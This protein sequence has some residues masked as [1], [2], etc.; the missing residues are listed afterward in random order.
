MPKNKKLGDEDIL[1]RVNAKVQAS[2]SWFDSKVSKENEKVEQY[3]D[4]VLPRKQK[5]GNSGYVS[6]D[7][8][9]SVESMKAQ[10]LETFGGGY[11]IVRFD[12]QGPEDVKL[13]RSCTLYTEK[14]IFQHND[15]W[16]IF[17][18][19]IDTGLKARNAVAQVYWQ[20]KTAYDEHSFSRM[21]LSQAQGLA[22]QEDVEIEAEQNPF[23]AIDIEPTYKGSWRRKIDKGGVKI[24]V[25]P[26]EEF[27]VEKRV[28]CR[29]DG[30]RGRRH[31]KTRQDLLDEGY[32]KAKVAKAGT[33][34]ADQIKF[35]QEA[36]ARYATTD[37]G[38]ALNGDAAQPELEPILLY[39]TYIEL[40]LEDRKAL[41]HVVHTD[42]VLFSCDEVD[43][44]PYVE[45]AP[46]RRAHAWYGNNYAAK[47][48]PTQ[49]ARTVLTRGVLDHT[50][51]TINPRW[52]VLN[53][54][55]QTPRE[56]LD[57]RQGGVVN[58]KMRDG[59]APLP[60]ANLNPHVF[61]VLEM[62]K[63][64]KEETTG[65]SALSQGLNKDAIS[66]Q[67]S[68]GLVGDLVALSQVRQ[69]VVARNF[70]KFVMDL[71]VKVYRCVVE[72]DRRERIEEVSG[73]YIEV[74]PKDWI[75]QRDVT[76]SLHL[77]YG[78]QEKRAMTMTTAYAGIAQDPVLSQ[79]FTLPKRRKMATD[80]LEERG[81]KNFDEYLELAENVQPPQP[82]PIELAKAQ[83]DKARADAALVTAQAGA[84]KVEQDGQLGL[85]KQQ[86]AEMQAQL[87]AILD[88]READRQD[89]DV[90]N[91]V[92]VSQR[93][94]ELAEAA[95][96]ESANNIISPN[97]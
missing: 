55:L 5:E 7:V 18:D 67:N 88:A 91:R 2:V 33:A 52:Q 66:T 89:L 92:D 56:L 54:A 40:V 78:E 90:A 86:L 22:S 16:F 29:T 42:S 41:Y 36:Q 71:W 10:L 63:Q 4:Q 11:K 64:N 12:P 77:G 34:D 83:A 49:N 65:I 27:F 35:S 72:N 73:E 28:K 32:D 79:A 45:F 96:A 58:V 15:G 26:P 47:S 24:E 30:A 69:K 53:G 13:A 43:E 39:E 61:S 8:Y 87:Q 57:G 59:I 20:D 19:V 68:Q 93:E 21:P 14:V 1:R 85:M 51:Q 38:V 74:N 50:A 25:I 46:L 94:I 17:H 6:S 23:S 31:V 97:G 84:K 48:I 95:P 60:Y 44:D 75:S 70:A 76:L 9:D 81:I 37:E 3:Y 82:D 80:I 62:L